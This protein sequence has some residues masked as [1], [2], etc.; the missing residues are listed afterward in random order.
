M[1]DYLGPIPIPDPPVILP[2]PLRSDYGG[3]MEWEPPIATHSFDQPGLKTEQRF[4]LGDGARRFQ[5]RRN[6]LSC[7]EYDQLK[8]HWKQAQGT[9]AEFDYTYHSPGGPEVVR[10][11]Y[12]DPQL[13]FQHAVGLAAGTG[14]ALVEVSHDTP[15]YSPGSILERFPDSALQTALS[16]QDQH[17]IPLVGV[18][19]R[20]TGAP[21]P[22]YLSDRRLSVSGQLYLP[23]LLSFQGIRQ[24]MGEAS[25]SALFTFG[26][27]D[28]VWTKLA[29]QVNLFRAL[30]QFALLHVESNILV[31]LWSGYALPWR[32]GSD[33]QFQ[34]GASDG[35]FELGLAYPSRLVTRACW[36]V[37]KGR[38]CP[39]T[40]PLESC[41]K[42]WEACNERG[43]PRSFGGVVMPQQRV[44]VKDNSTGTWGYGRSTLTSVTVAQDSIY[45]RP[46]QEVYTDK[47]MVVTA[48]VAGGR[49]ESDFYSALGIIGE[50]PISGF[51]TNLLKHKLDDQPPHDPQRNGGWRYAGG[52]DPANPQ[53]YF[54]LSQEPWG[55]TPP[56][57]TYAGG[58]AFAEIRRSDEKGLQLSKVADRKMTVTVSGGIG[59]WIWH[60]P[61][62]REWHAPLSNTVWIAINVYLR[63]LGLRAEPG[64]EIPAEAMEEF[65]DVEQAIAMASICDDTVPK[66]VG[67]GTERQFPFRGAIQE[68]KPLKD[69]I[70]EILNCCLGYYTFVNGKLWVGIRFHSGATN[71]FT[72][73]N[74]LYKTLQL[75]PIQPS[76]NWLTGEFGD[77]EYDWHLNNVTVYDIDQASFIG[78][79]SSPQY[80]QSTMNFVG[81]SNKSQ[82]ARIVTTRLREELGGVGPTEQLNARSMSFRTTV[83]AL[84]TMVGEVISLDHDTLPTGRC[85]GRIRS[86]TL[87][88]DYSID[89]DATPT[90]NSMYDL[91][92]GPKPEDV[93]AAPVPPELLPSINGLTWMPNEVGPVAGDPLYRDERERTFALWQD[94]TI[95]RDGAWGAALYVAGQMAINQFEPGNQPR[96]LGAR[97]VDGGDL[98]GP[99]TVYA[100]IT[101]RDAESQPYAPSNLIGLWI[102]AGVVNKRVEMVVAASSEASGKWDLWA[103]NDRR[104][105]ALQDSFP[106]TPPALVYLP[107]P[108]HRMTVG[109]PEAAARA[110]AI[111]AKLVWHSGIVGVLVTGVPANNQ[112][113]SND[114]VGSTDNWI[115]RILSTLADQSDGSAPLWNFTVVAFDAPSGTFTVT[116]DCVR[117][118]PEDSVEP[119]DVLIMRSIAVSA[120]DT[121]VTD[122]MW[123]N[124]VTRLQFGSPGL[125]PQEEIGRVLRIL[126]G[127]G[128]GQYRLIV[129]ND[130]TSITVSPPFVERPDQT[131]VIIV[132]AD[133]WSYQ[134]ES[135]QL[136]VPLEG[137]RVEIRMR[138]ENLRD[139]VALVAG[140]LVDDRGR[141]SDEAVAP[142]REIYVFGQPPT[143]REVGP[144]GGPWQALA[145]DHTIRANTSDN[146]IRVELPPL[147]VYQGRSLLVF[148]DG[149]NDLTV[150]AF[151]G[152]TMFDGSTE[153][154]V[155][156]GASLHITAG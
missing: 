127:K 116:P 1:P 89:I 55:A 54:G 102:G 28:D 65:F 114:F 21:P 26:N 47:D 64:H 104:T 97:L 109:M 84:S 131:S 79:P 41:P 52:L 8:T 135:S 87:N 125:R 150:A 58:L 153:V 92:F 108:L 151:P 82:A 16:A 69:W 126:Y 56:G 33:G 117:G 93:A 75:A 5:F 105:I 119:G 48:D 18:A 61:G 66:L 46:V 44:R 12:A 19:P 90:T 95:T 62:A 113:Q 144:D 138:V 154:L 133:D 49:D 20:G 70:Q 57:S 77:E 124:S 78:T 50:G 130:A 99:M 88:P 29:N 145:T 27:A 53:D 17:I 45:Q 9:Y 91:T 3:G 36:K 115:G 96:I 94:Y 7:D 11:R 42:S 40:S 140:F 149:T 63:G 32:F 106:G 23:R 31:K 155:L 121:K 111:A 4:I 68:R 122:P 34:L 85:E 86:W 139:H 72:R 37:Y 107:G 24:T 30:V 83:L 156:P 103:G 51:A 112:I 43:V 101:Q 80:Q 6:R 98:D 73:A 118:A 141:Y 142:M 137:F 2:F 38:F 100:A 15:T 71:A 136:E 59:G 60:A 120:T 128:A 39:S 143:V 76:F 10:V 22:M 35:V 132:E 147:Y 14:L 67:G 81:V 134:T 110:V 146:A 129:D 25:D 123:D 13:E 148:N 152:E 74:I